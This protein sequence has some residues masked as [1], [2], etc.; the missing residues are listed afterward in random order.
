VNT[1]AVW[2]RHVDKIISQEEKTEMNDNEISLSPK[3]PEP[4]ELMLD[5][6]FITV[7]PSSP[8]VTV[9]DNNPS[10][11]DIEPT[12]DLPRTTPEMP[13]TSTLLSES[14]TASSTRT[15]SEPVKAGFSSSGHKITVPNKF[16]DFVIK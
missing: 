1:T 13:S 16:K 12:T 10:V 9:N 4:S 6:E 15:V 7:Q 5:I 14:N 3:Q 8:S 11:P 2:K